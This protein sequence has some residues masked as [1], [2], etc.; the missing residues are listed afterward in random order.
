MD[1]VIPHPR[2]LYCPPGDFFIDPRRGVQTAVITHAHSDH[3]APGSGGYI[4]SSRCAPLV[5]QRIGARF[6]IRPVEYGEKFR[7]GGCWVS[8]HPAGHILGS[9]Q[10][11]I[12]W[13]DEV[14]VVSGDYKRD[15]DPSCEPFEVVACDVFITETT[16]G[17][18]LYQWRPGEEIAREVLA[19]RGQARECGRNCILYC[20]SLGK[21][22]R[23]L[24]ELGRLD[25]GVVY[26]H[27]AHLAPTIA[28]HEMG[29][30]M[31][32]F[33][34]AGDASKRELIQGE[35][36]L[37]PPNARGTKWE[38]SLGECETAF[39]SGWMALA[40][41][42]RNK[43]YDRGFVISDHADWNSLLRTIRETGARRVIAM[44]GDAAA[45]VQ[46]LREQGLQAEELAEA[47]AV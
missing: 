30:P 37:A 46:T 5:R 14:W 41:A 29:I 28:Y 7:L 39:A 22:Q 1:L 25:A 31:A 36:V 13:R 17:S 2:G 43:G 26:L 16:F 38:A 42:R 35:L 27:G 33:Q 45:L 10:V 34:L 11:R 21:A 32:K 12:E 24:A 9:A 15:P 23:L 4:C 6:N 19:W 44:H 47:R 18:P 3:V 8:L 40:N 20:Y